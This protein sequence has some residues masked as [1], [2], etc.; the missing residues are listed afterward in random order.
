MNTC[1]LEV[2]RV[3]VRHVGN[4]I[5]VLDPGSLNVVGRCVLLLGLGPMTAPVQ[6]RSHLFRPQGFLDLGFEIQRD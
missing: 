6:V 3:A 5:E 1:L 2:T 4:L